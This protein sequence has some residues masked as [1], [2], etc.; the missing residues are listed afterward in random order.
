MSQYLV[1]AINGAKARFFTLETAQFPEYESSPNLK[2][3]S[4]LFSSTKE[5]LG[6]ELWANTKTGRN[7][8]I[9]GITHSYDDRRQAHIIEFERRFVSD[10]GKTIVDLIENH[11]VQRL[12]LI[13]EPQILGLIR[14]TL[15]SILPKN[16]KVNELAKDLCYLKSNQLHEYL[17]NKRL[18]PR[19]KKVVT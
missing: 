10:I 5:L 12:I 13:A 18:L 8:G 11:Q 16:F 1:T 14:D 4:C 6:K 7:R 2:E 17:A 15:V 3:H 9:A 19:T